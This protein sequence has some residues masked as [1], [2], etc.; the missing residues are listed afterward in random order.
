MDSFMFAPVGKF[1][2][3]EGDAD[4][5]FA[6]HH[7]KRIAAGIVRGNAVARVSHL[8]CVDTRLP[9][10]L[11]CSGRIPRRSLHAPAQTKISAPSRRARS[12]AGCPT[13]R[14]SLRRPRRLVLSRLVRLCLSRAPPQGLP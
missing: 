11:P 1:E 3:G 2:E 9:F 8:P 7:R 5:L 12:P 13:A 6:I 10:P 4:P 14:N